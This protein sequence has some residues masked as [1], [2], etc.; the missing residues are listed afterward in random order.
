MRA[1]MEGL[2]HNGSGEF[3]TDLYDLV[4]QTGIEKLSVNYGGIQYLSNARAD[5]NATLGA[6]MKNMKFTFQEKQLER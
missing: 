1:E 2:E 4:M 6:D 5:W 3:G